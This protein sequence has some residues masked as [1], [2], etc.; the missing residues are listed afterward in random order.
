MTEIKKLTKIVMIY[1]GIAGV[2]FSLLYLIFIDIQLANWPWPD[3]VPFWAMGS[4]MLV[5]AIASFL[6]FFRR[7]WGEIRIYFEIMI[8]QGI[9]S[10]LMDIAIVVV[11]PLNEAVMSQM[12]FNFI[13]LS[14]NL[15]IGLLVYIKQ[16]A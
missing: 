9:G 3:P 13:I 1:Y 14:F 8:M 11:V 7:E 2:L 16:R 5:L 6:A 10:I 4:S 12:I 15:I